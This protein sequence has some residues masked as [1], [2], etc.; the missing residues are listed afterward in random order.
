MELSQHS[1]TDDLT[2]PAASPN[3]AQSLPVAAPLPRRT[4]LIFAIACG[5]VVA[6]LYYAQPMLNVIG[7]EFHSAPGTVGLVITLTQVGYAAGL[8]FLVPLGDLLNRRR[9]VITVLLGTTL[10]LVATAIS[11]TLTWLTVVSLIVG[12]TSVVAQVLIP[13]A[14]SLSP[15]ADRGRVVGTIMSGLLLGIL[16]ARTFSGLVGQVSSWRA[17]YWLAAA[18]MLLLVVVLR[19]ELPREDP[20]RAA[21]SYGSLLRSVGRIALEEPLLRRRA[22]YGA[23]VFAAF[24]VFW[25][26]AAFLLSRPPYNYNQAV[27]GLFGLAGVAGALCASVAGRLSDRGLSRIATGVFLLCALLSFILLG[28]GGH[29]L[30]PLIL[31]VVVLDLGV[32]GTH[33]TN[34]SEI[35]RLRPEARSRLTTVYMVA[36]FVG[37][38]AGSATAAIV[39]ARSG[40][41]GVCL[42]GATFI[43][44]ALAF[45]LTEL[46]PQHPA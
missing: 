1:V 44:L 26:V 25:T 3:S 5:L 7:R 8:L 42:L 32:Q 39:Y 31:G 4:V 45:W 41:T 2:S 13:F 17:V 15:A 24:S 28:I 10:A 27:I 21:L 11:P 16:L 36:Y 33:I 9:L 19:R 35:Y 18:L 34:Q 30:I 22:F 14:A 40:W 20:H 6:N 29:M 23:M 43:A 46:L 12:V 38:S 37:G